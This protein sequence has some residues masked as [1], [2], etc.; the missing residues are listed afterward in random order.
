MPELPEV[1]TLRRQLETRIVG[2]TIKAVSVNWPKMV[3]PLS[4]GQFTKALKGKRI[5][6]VERRAKILII[7]LSAQQFVVVH[8]KMTGQLIFQ[9]KKGEL[10]VG[11]HPQ[12]GGLD[13]LPNK[14]THVTINFTDGSIL[15]F[16]DLRKFGWMRLVDQKILNEM[17]SAYGIEPLSKEFTLKRF[18]EII[19][20]YPKRNI[21]KILMDQE[22]IAGVGNIY[23]DES[24]YSAGV[25]PMR[26]AH[27]VADLEIKSLHHHLKRILNVSIL[28]KG[29]SARNYLTAEGIAGGYVKYL[30][31]YGRQRDCCKKC[32]TQLVKIKLNGR[33]THYCPQCQ[34]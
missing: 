11:G 33:G 17:T 5:K 26:L 34:R 7:A 21:K 31:V 1:E 8:L 29:T 28:K 10:V 19:R 9:P 25:R 27:D 4:A 3:R 13:N 12:S 30:N 14:Y 6:S 20:R 16:N 23:A 18:T 22:L 32:K 24:C 2:K 15:Y